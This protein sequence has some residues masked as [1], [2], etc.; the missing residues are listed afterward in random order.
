M[1]TRLFW[2]GVLALLGV[3]VWR[4]RPAPLQ[5]VHIV[6]VMPGS[7]PIA[8]LTLKYG[9]GMRPQSII[10]D[11][12][13]PKGSGSATVD[14]CQEIV[15]VLIA[16]ELDGRARVTATAGYRVLGRLRERVDVFQNV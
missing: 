4:G 9:A 12:E 3:T 6:A 8:R 1:R 5:R 15:D 14:G 11:V 16:G 2:L 7:P 10:L 13:G